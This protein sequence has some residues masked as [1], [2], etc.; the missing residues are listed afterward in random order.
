MSFSTLPPDLQ[1]NILL[2]LSP[3]DL[4]NICQ[5]NH[6]FHSLCQND[7]R[8]D[9]H[10]EYLTKS[11]LRIDR[12]YGNN[13]Y[14]TFL[15]I[16]ND[17]HIT[18]NKLIELI[19]ARLRKYIN[20]N[21]IRTELIDHLRQTLLSEKYL[22]YTVSQLVKGFFEIDEDG[23]PGFIDVDIN[24]ENRNN[25]MFILLTKIIKHHLEIYFDDT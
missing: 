15:N 19:P 22:D 14:Q 12:L 6:H 25:E 13:W 7:P 16:Y 1:I 24:I 9:Q 18:A 8:L 20:R 23:L 21:E 11:Y 2:L 4:L 17:L 5:T 3:I 10:F